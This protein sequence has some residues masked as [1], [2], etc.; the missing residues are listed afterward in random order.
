[1]WMSMLT[2]QLHAMSNWDEKLTWISWG[3]D[4]FCVSARCS[5]GA[6]QQKV[7]F[8]TS[9]SL[10]LAL[11][12]PMA[13]CSGIRTIDVEYYYRIPPQESTQIGLVDYWNP[14]CLS[15]AG[16]DPEVAGSKVRLAQLVSSVVLIT[17]RSAVRARCWIFFLLWTPLLALRFQRIKFQ[18]LNRT[19]CREMTS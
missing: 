1:M 2:L 3:R 14:R 4:F 18:L 12:G 6:G 16:A 10:L 17:R 11:R 5:C 13:R 7:S 8:S 9:L 15:Q 19:W